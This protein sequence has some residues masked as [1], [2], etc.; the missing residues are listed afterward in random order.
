MKAIGETTKN[1]VKGFCFKIK[2]QYK[3]ITPLE[4]L[5][6]NFYIPRKIIVQYLQ[7]NFYLIFYNIC[8]VKNF[9]FFKIY[10]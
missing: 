8:N 4:L 3:L 6:V 2:K 1:K 7:T 5:Y 10:L 9:R